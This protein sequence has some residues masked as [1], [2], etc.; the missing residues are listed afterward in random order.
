M[1][2]DPTQKGNGPTQFHDPLIRNGKGKARIDTSTDYSRKFVSLRSRI[3]Y[4]S[5]CILPYLAICVLVYLEGL[6]A[7][8]IMMLT[9][10]LVLL[11]IF[12]YIQKKLR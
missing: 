10:P 6:E 12:W 9:L 5:L 4:M 7:L 2:K 1:I 3:I 11:S 8:G